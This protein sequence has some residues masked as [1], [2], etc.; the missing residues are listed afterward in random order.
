MQTR[1]IS[2]RDNDSSTIPSESGKNG[3]TRV[4]DEPLLQLSLVTALGTLVTCCALQSS[5]R[6]KWS[7]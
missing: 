7:W 1:V 3:E 2:G 6:V 5:Q 4:S